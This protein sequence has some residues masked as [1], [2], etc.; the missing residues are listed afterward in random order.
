MAAQ[1]AA[2]LF[3]AGKHLDVVEPGLEDAVDHIMGF[4]V[5]L[6]VGRVE[7]GR[8]RKVDLVLVVI[9]GR[10]RKLRLVIFDRQRA[11]DD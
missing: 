8:P 11:L 2:L 10:Q 1:F 3:G 7:D 5:G 4:F 6:A 9:I